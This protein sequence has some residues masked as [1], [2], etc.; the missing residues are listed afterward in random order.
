MNTGGK[1][2]IG[3]GSGCLVIV[4]IGVV[5]FISCTVCA[6]AAITEG[7]EQAERE[8]AA[9]LAVDQGAEKQI[10]W[11]GEVQATCQRYDAA[12]NDIQKSAVFQENQGFVRGKQLVSIRGELESASTGHG[13]GGLL[14]ATK[15][16]RARFSEAFI[17][18]SDPIY[19]QAASLTVGQCVVF[20]G[21]V[22]DT[23]L[24]GGL[25][26]S[27]EKARICRMSYSFDFTSI[28]PC[29]QP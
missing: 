28:S 16:G 21:G 18:E 4:I 14:L 26:E 17:Q 12:P 19:S 11:L 29:P 15:V 20:S 5:G 10:P 22:T 7:V 9:Q 13:G 8:E 23:S 3:L 1:V 2:A 6:G 24:G 27:M 25:L